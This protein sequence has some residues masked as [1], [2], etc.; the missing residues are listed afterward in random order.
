M[1]KD[2][3][4]RPIVAGIYCRL[5]D[6]REGQRLGVIRQ[7]T[8]NK[9]LVARLNGAVHRVF[10]DND[11]SVGPTSNKPRPDYA[12]M[13]KEARAGQIN[14]VVA[15]STSRL[16]RRPRE[17][18]DLIDLAVE[19]GI[20]FYF[21]VSPPWDLNTADGRER[22]RQDAARDRGEVERLQER[23]IRK[24]RQSAESGEY[25]GGIRAY[26][27]GH[28]IGVNPAN[29]KEV[30]DWTKLDESEVK[31]MREIADRILAGDSQ[32]M[33]VKDFAD[34]GILTSK[35]Y[36][37]TVG[38]LKRTLLNETYVQFDP[39]D[40]EKRGT[41]LH[42][43][44][45]H[46]AVWPAI[47]TQTEHGMLLNYFKHNPYNWQQGQV[48]ARRYLLTGFTKCGSCGGDMRGMGKTDDNGKYIRR[49]GCKKYNL[50]GEV[51]GCNSVFRIAEPLELLVTEAVLLRF[52]SPQVAQALA[53]V[54]DRARVQQL[55][56]ELLRL[57]ERRHELAVEHA[58]TPLE[59][60]GIM[61][62][63]IKGKSDEIHGQLNKLRNDKAKAAMVPAIGS[64]RERFETA[65]MEW[66]AS[67]IRLV[68]EKVVVN[69]SRGWGSKWRGYQFSPKDVQIIW[70][71]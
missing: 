14:T 69:P 58:L 24:K 43:G 3:L 60:Y 62:A 36:P 29:A 18:E 41:R 17:V 26:G 30:R 51:V 10:S 59:D 11:T 66:K 50:R 20:R 21:V 22:A 35:G 16:T 45:K 27:I 54:E 23:I 68:V 38:K 2:I 19:Y 64:I 55:T 47:F 56:E 32:L 61:V 5:S 12:D 71:K 49:Y 40:P 7:E 33:I 13:L 57:Q 53:P 28:L 4:D 1:H 8:D 46:R 48:I 31:V 52:D 15:Y 44:N 34:R 42:N 67:V 65:S 70:S 37:W 25:P 6:D 9:G 63:T 39:S